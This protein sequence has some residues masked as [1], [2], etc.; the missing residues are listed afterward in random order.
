MTHQHSLASIRSTVVNPHWT[1]DR[2]LA[3]GFNKALQSPWLALAGLAGI[4]RQTETT[5][6]KKVVKILPRRCQKL[7]LWS[8]TGQPKA[9]G[10]IRTFRIESHRA[11]HEVQ[12]WAKFKM[13][14]L[15]Q[16]SGLPSRKSQLQFVR[17]R[18]ETE[19]LTLLKTHQTLSLYNLLPK[20]FHILSHLCL[21]REL[22]ESSVAVIHSVNRKQRLA[23]YY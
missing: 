12:C 11:E 7:W 5:L 13:F 10:A 8:H 15:L 3:T 9:S 22:D 20:Y 18:M 21:L 23:G 1:D 6:A 2:L 4:R 19:C 14:R 16:I 17:F